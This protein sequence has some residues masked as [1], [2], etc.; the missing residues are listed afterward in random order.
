MTHVMHRRSAAAVVVLLRAV[1]PRLP[2][3][4]PHGRTGTPPGAGIEQA[5]GTGDVDVQ[6]AVRRGAPQAVDRRA[7]P[8]HAAGGH[9]GAVPQCV[10]G[11]APAGHLRGRRLGR[12]ALQLPRQ[13]RLRHGLAQLHEAHRPGQHHD[14]HRPWAP[15]LAHRGPLEAGRLAPG[16]RVRGRPS[17]HRAAVLHQLGSAALRPGRTDG[18]RRATADCCGHSRRAA[19]GRRRTTGGRAHED[20][21][22]TR[23]ARGRGRREPGDPDARANGREGDD[24]QS[25]CRDEPWS[26]RPR[27][28]AHPLRA[29]PARDLR[30]GL[31]LGR[32]G[33]LAQGARRRGDRGRLHR[34]THAESELR[35]R[36]AA[37]APG[38]PRR[39]SS[40]STPPRSATRSCSRSSGRRTTRRAAI[41]RARIAA[42]SIAPRSSPSVRISR[43]RPSPRVPRSSSGS[44]TRSRPRSPRPASSGWRRTTTSNGTRST[45]PSHAR[46]RTGRGRSRSFAPSVA[47]IRAA[48]AGSER[49]GDAFTLPRTTRSPGLPSSLRSAPEGSSPR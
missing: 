29:E 41:A 22:A 44:R 14:P 40:S 42:A 3:A 6:E 11:R 49:A 39:S 16:S 45:A 25:E 31:L 30:P 32:G 34:R 7:V 19:N 46:C 17:A 1:E 28:P 5:R 33:A 37:T 13:V 24:R 8:G 20:R 21:P 38:T 43:R 35:G 9:G 36:S 15:P 2:D 26:R 48:A 18:R 4:G 47:R 23:R 27:H 10:L 12:A